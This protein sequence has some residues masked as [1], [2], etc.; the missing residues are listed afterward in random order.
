M[1]AGKPAISAAAVDDAAGIGRHLVVH[2]PCQLIVAQSGMLL[3]QLS[4]ST[5][6]MR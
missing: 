5:W 6:S 3:I 4:T 1:P 2:R